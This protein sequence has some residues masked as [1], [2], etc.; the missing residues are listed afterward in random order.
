V[1]FDAFD[2]V[3]LL[4]SLGEAGAH[5]DVDAFETIFFS[6]L[7]GEETMSK[8]QSPPGS[9]SWVDLTVPD[10]DRVR[11]FYSAVVGWKSEPVAMGG[12]NDYVMAPPQTA[13]GV[14]GI[15]HARGVNEGLPASW[16]IYI[17]V[18]NIDES[19]RSCNELGGKVMAGPKEMGA[20][21]RYCV[22]QDPAGAVAALVEPKR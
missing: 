22:I 20:Y 10:A 5:P 19:I 1:S 11:D 18:E 21:G 8:Q 2:R 7:L 12:Y 3:R 15:C 13:T 16:L 9:I 17:T 4:A 6:S 14:A